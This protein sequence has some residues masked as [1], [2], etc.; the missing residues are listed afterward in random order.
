MAPEISPIRIL[1]FEQWPPA[2]QAL[3]TTNCLPGD[4]F[5]DPSYGASLRPDSLLKVRKGYGRWLSFLA[6]RGWL[7]ESVV[8]LVRVSRG[9]LRAYFQDLRA[10]GNADYTIIGRFAELTMAMK[11]LAPGEDVS[12]IRRPT[13]RTIYASLLKQKRQ[14]IVPDGRVLFCWAL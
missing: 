10:A 4:P 3:W 11:I 8:P 9:R 5:D 7:D 14:L 6:S 1:K 12:W 2:D 13:G